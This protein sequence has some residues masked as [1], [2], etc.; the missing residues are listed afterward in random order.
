VKN[1]VLVALAVGLLVGADKPKKDKGT[2]VLEGTWV[3]VSLTENGFKS[4]E[5]GK[6]KVVFQGKNMTVK[7]EEITPQRLT[8]KIDPDKK[9]ID[10]ISAEG[11]DKDKTFKGIYQLKKRELKICF[12]PPDKDRP[13]EFTSEEHSYHTLLVLKRA[14]PK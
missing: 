7:R 4:D 9:T 6:D 8:Y 11:D 5:T 12:A 1:F 2:T 13:K 14:K 3:I 10:I